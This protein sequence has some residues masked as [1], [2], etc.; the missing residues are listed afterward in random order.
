MEARKAELRWAVIV[1]ELR[2]NEREEQRAIKQQ[3]REEERA[4]K[5][6]EKA[7][8]EAAKEEKLLEEALVKAR[9]ELEGASVEQEAEFQRQLEELEQKLIEANEKNQRAISMAQQTKQGHVYV[10]SNVGSFGDDVFKI[11]LTRR[12]EPIDRIRELGDASVP[13]DFD[14]HAMMFSKDAPALETE[15]HKIFRDYQVNLVNPRKEF[16]RVGIS[17]IKKTV[18]KMG[19]ESKWMMIAEAHEYR[20]TLAVLKSQGK[21]VQELPSPQSK[22]ISPSVAVAPI[23]DIPVSTP[24]A[25]TSALADAP[26]ADPK[27]SASTVSHGSTQSRKIPTPSRLKSGN[28]Q[29]PAAPPEQQN[30]PQVSNGDKASAPPPLSGQTKG[31]SVPCPGCKG[32]LVVST[33][34]IGKNTCPHCGKTFNVKSK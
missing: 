12:L 8:K 15:L 33:L 25:A 21:K 3:M 23:P 11:G 9:R 1:N 18:Q 26:V 10:I 27:V 19:I 6:Y 7:I 28:V 22:D 32:P 30:T 4:R 34:R 20:E 16:F 14:I 13:F 17:N 31:R 24:R 5:E 29:L 2:M